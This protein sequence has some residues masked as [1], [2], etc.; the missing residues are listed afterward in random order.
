MK[1]AQGF[2][3]LPSYPMKLHLFPRLALVAALGLSASALHAQ[4]DKDAADAPVPPSVL[5][6]YDRNK[7]GKLDEAERAKWQ[8]DLAARREK[9]QAERRAM[10]ERFDTNKD[11]RLS[12][13]EHAAAKI[14]MQKERSEKDAERMKERAAKERAEREKAE[15]QAAEKAAEKAPEKP[16]KD[17]APADE[18]GGGMMM[19]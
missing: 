16:A 12:E 13:E 19:Q 8:A 17:A 6:R 3:S 5:A 7:D 18:M 10:L 2:G 15:K 4:N 1:P 11:G 9:S 14:E